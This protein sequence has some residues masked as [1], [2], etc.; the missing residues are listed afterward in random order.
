MPEGMENNSRTRSSEPTK[1]GVY[2]LTETQATRIVPALTCTRS[3][4]YAFS[5]NLVFS[6]DS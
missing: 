4:V 3:S 1:Q 2:E 6:W 5:I